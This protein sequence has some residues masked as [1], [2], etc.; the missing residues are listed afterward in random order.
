M[1][2]SSKSVLFLGDLHCGSAY[3][4]CSKNP[5]IGDTGG[6]WK[7][8]RLQTK[9]YDIWT[10]MKD[11]LTQKP[12]AVIL[13]G[14]LI[15]GANAK[16]IGQQS[17]TTDI[18]DQIKDAYNLISEFKPKHFLMTRG[19]GYH[20]QKDATSHEE[21]LANM[22]N[23][24]PYS[25]YFRSS[26]KVQDYDN[27]RNR[28]TRTDYYL[29]FSIYGKVFSVTHHIGFNRWFAYRTTALAREMA[30]MEFLRGRYW[31]PEDM[32]SVIVRNHVHYF[33]YVRFATQHGFTSPA[34]KMPDAHL[35]RG[36][37]GGTAPSIGGVECIVDSDGKITVEPHIVSNDNYPKMSVL[38]L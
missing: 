4:L 29:N 33:V 10:W 18:N 27:S 13:N 3:A 37:L 19:S 23:C 20:V 7:P 5:T 14:D 11:S 25:G 12:Y 28:I 24:T 22:L 8:N 31:K 35:F 36:G 9:L 15:D 6:E 1:A 2:K 30:D 32:P 26:E 16:Q 38:K 34:F 17:W 21:I